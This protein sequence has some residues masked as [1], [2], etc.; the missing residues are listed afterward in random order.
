MRSTGEWPLV[1]VAISSGIVLLV[2]GII[3]VTVCVTRKRPKKEQEEVDADENP[4]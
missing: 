2:V 1:E 4:L 3:A